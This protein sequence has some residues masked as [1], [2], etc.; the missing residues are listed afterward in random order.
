LKIRKLAILNGS[1]W[2]FYG[3]QFRSFSAKG[4]FASGGSEG[5]ANSKNVTMR[6]VILPAINDIPTFLRML[7]YPKAVALIHICA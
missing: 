5:R 7:E 4:G 3:N 1:F 2:N 6:D